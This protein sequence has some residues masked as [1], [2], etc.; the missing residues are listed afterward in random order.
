[1]SMNINAKFKGKLIR[2]FKNDM[3][4]LGS[5]HQCTWNWDFDGILL[6]KVEDVW[7]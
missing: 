6:F 4:N 1:M 7:A 5:F 3:R 2:T